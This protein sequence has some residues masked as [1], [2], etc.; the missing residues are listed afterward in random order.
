MASPE[1]PPSRCASWRTVRFSRCASAIARSRPLLLWLLSGMS[2]SGPSGSKLRGVV[3]ERDRKRCDRVRVVD[4]AVEPRALLARRLHGFADHHETGG[5]DLHVLARAAE[6]L[7]PALDVGIEGAAGRDVALRGEHRFGGLR[8]EAPAGV[9]RA[10]LHDHRPALH[11]TRNVERA[12]HREILALVAEHV[13]PGGIEEDAAVDVADEGIV[14]PRVPQAGHDIVEFARALVALAVL[15][16]CVHA[17]IQRRVGVGGGD[18]VPAGAAAAQM[19]ERGEAARD[20]IGRVERGRAGRHQ[21][22]VLGHLRQ[23]RKQRERLERRDGVAALQAP[24]PACSAPP[25]GRP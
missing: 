9:R 18:D 17:E 19:I 14:R 21:A 5:Q 6:L 11:G 7:H 24:R 20:V 2:G 8:R 13:H 3:A 15:H 10:G 12:A 16:Q 25:C 23:C 22:D 4:E 1:K